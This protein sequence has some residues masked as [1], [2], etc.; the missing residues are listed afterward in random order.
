M[1]D[2]TDFEAMVVGHPQLVMTPLQAMFAEAEEELRAECPDGFEV[3]EIVERA[4]FQLPEAEREAAR[5][6]LN[7]VYWEARIADE[8]NLAHSDELQAQRQ[9][10][11][12]LLGRFEDLA[13]GS[14]MV[15]Y[16]LLAEIAR[17][18][19]PLMGTAS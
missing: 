7:T 4:F 14:G 13:Q 19:L 12:R 1:S 9:E 16:A 8:A 10:L 5:R 18:S 6:E 15:P 2:L 17:L 3:H 11:R